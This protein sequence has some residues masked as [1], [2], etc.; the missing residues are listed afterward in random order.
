[1]WLGLW[2]GQSG[3]R[4]PVEARYSAKDHSATEAKTASCKWVN[5]LFPGVKRWSCGFDHQTPS[6]TEVKERADLYP[7]FLFAFMAFYRVNF[8]SVLPYRLTLFQ[9]ACTDF[10]WVLVRLSSRNNFS[11]KEIL[12]KV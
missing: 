9:T 11:F 10:I 2:A 4:T 12:K 6:R 5:L 3:V 7:F 1:L 8:N